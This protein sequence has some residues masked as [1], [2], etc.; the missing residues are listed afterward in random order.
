MKQSERFVPASL[1]WVM[2]LGLVIFTIA[3][4][5]G[6]SASDR[7]VMRTQLP[8]LTRTPLPTLTPTLVAA[9]AEITPAG[10]NGGPG[11]AA[12]L[13]A[14]LMQVGAQPAPDGV[15]AASAPLPEVIPA[16]VEQAANPAITDS[17]SASS[18]NADPAGNLVPAGAVVRP[19]HVAAP[20]STPAAGPGLA[21]VS[22]PQLISAVSNTAPVVA[23]VVRPFVSP[24]PRPTK[25]PLPTRMATPA[26][27][28]NLEPTATPDFKTSG[29][30]F[31]STRISGRS[32]GGLLLY[33]EVINDTGSTQ[34]L[35]YISGTFYNDGGQIIAGRSNTADF[36]PIDT[37]SPGER[38]PFE[39]TVNNVDSAARFDLW[40]RSGSGGNAPRRNNFEFL[41]VTEQHQNDTYCL[42]GSLANRGNDLDDYV[43]IVA[44]LYDDRNNVIKFSESYQTEVE[45]LSGDETLAFEFCVDSLDDEVAR[46]DLRAWGQ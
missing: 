44:I 2:L 20:T 42:S 4:G 33:G 35:Y 7:I 41:D 43:D 11:T 36:I 37:L 13:P 19:Q 38:V 18:P 5:A 27:A 1:W 23:G 8:A 26:P 15:V 14:P 39:L 6:R 17:A 22:G 21:A 30:S 45:D 16:A 31:A 3:C 34:E 28:I 12:A 29:W 24:T 25:I 32:D 46:Y 9:A 40:A 10:E